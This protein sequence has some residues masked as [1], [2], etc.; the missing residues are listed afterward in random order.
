MIRLDD[1]CAGNIV[2]YIITLQNELASG[3]LADSQL[4]ARVFSS[5]LLRL[6][7]LASLAKPHY[8]ST[9]EYTFG[10]EIL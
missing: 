10:I 5:L 2:S 9:R 6:S 4:A 7:I 3:I 8:D 1:D